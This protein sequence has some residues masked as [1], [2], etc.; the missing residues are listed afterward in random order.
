MLAIL[1]AN[2]E[3]DPPLGFGRV[4]YDHQPFANRAF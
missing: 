1:P 4:G 3:R 2:I